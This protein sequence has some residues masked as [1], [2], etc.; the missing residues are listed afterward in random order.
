MLAEGISARLIEVLSERGEVDWIYTD[1]DQIDDR[2]VR[3]DPYLKAAFNLPLAVVDDYATR[4]AVV[5]RSTI[6]EVGGLRT[7]Y[8]Q[9]QIYELLLRVARAGGQI[10]HLAEIGCH[11]VGPMPVGL[12]EQ[13]HR[14]AERMVFGHAS[15]AAVERVTLATSGCLEIQ[16][17][18]WRADPGKAR[19][20]TIVI[21]TRDRLD[22][23]RDCI[24]SIRA[25]VEPTRTRILI[26][27]DQ[28][29]D[30]ETRGYLQL[31]EKDH[32]LRCRVIRSA[33]T[34]RVFNY[35]G[36]MNIAA[37]EVETPLVLH[38]NNDVRATAP[39]WLDQMAG[40]LSF[41]D[42]GIVGAKLLYPDDSIQH[43]GVVVS[44]GSGTLAHFQSG[45]R[46]DDAGYRRWPHLVREVSAVTGACLL[47]SAELFRTLGGFD[48]QHF[49]VQFNDIDFCLRARNTGRRVIYEPGAVL[50]H[51][52][53]ASRADEFDYNE[54]LRF[55]KKYAGYRDPFVSPHL[56]HRSICGPTPMLARE[57][58]ATIG[59]HPQWPDSSRTFGT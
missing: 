41:P 46:A 16:R 30:E 56:D 15:P 35:A 55:L 25:T 45:L 43:A 9:A 52:T 4:L 40:W 42:V 3:H 6:E 8:G 11:Q 13:H 47:T 48:E 50:Y 54:T 26:V 23:L 53:S 31:L 57:A 59:R 36:L 24:E 38:L 2:S 37:R 5:K 22:L 19:S 10:E 27:D 39:G 18:S 49:A 28:S 12:S 32:R 51:L 34:D 1:E 20:V 33:R 17:V 21:P 29:Q 7:E 58:R 44:P 14:A